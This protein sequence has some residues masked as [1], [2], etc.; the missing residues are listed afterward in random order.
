M[1]TLT[2]PLK[3]DET[4]TDLTV[5]GSRS[6]SLFE[7]SALSGAFRAAADDINFRAAVGPLGL[8]IADGS[9]AVEGDL[10]DAKVFRLGL[11]FDD[12]AATDSGRKLLRTI[13]LSEDFSA[14][15]AGSIS[16]ALPVYFPTDSIAKGRVLFDAGLSVDVLSGT[17]T[18]TDL[19]DSLRA[20]DLEGNP[21]DIGDLFS[22]DGL[23]DLS[24]FDNVL[25]LVEGVD[26][27]LGG[28]QDVLARSAD[29]LSEIPGIGPVTAR[30]LRETVQQTVDAALAE[31]AEE[32]AGE[33]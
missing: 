29:D 23:A 6:V 10:G 4:R 20:V 15:L 33:E 27:F 8:F 17:L 28:L 18:T 14:E 31:A 12:D 2:E 30:R 22:L 19:A 26:Q 5:T 24:L 25:L 11:D 16:A 9:V 21:I 3:T 7:T 1:L 32:S 13:E